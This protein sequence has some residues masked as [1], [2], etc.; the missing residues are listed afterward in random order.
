MDTEAAAPNIAPAEPRPSDN[1]VQSFA[2][3]LSVI[4]SF[5][6]SAPSQTVS[7]VARSTG[8]T[9]AGARRILL[10]LVQLGYMEATGRQFRLTP[11]ILDLGFAYISSLPLWSL[12]EPVLHTLAAQTQE[13]CSAAVLD[14]VDIVHVLRGPTHR[15]MSLHLGV[16]S[17]LPATCT[18]A[19]RVLLA[20]L[21]PDECRQRLQAAPR[22][23][24]TVRTLTEPRALQEAVDAVR[25]QGWCLV[26]Q[27]LEDGLLSLAAPIIDRGGRTVAA[28]DLSG[29]AHRTP[30]ALM[31][32]RFLPLL[33]DAA[34]QVSQLLQAKA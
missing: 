3:G 18:S 34:Q 21:P 2:R 5:S 8:L 26:D 11:R 25:S 23:A 6:H 27:E 30:P 20:T 24:F 10:T 12:A 16:G 13:S 29:Q 28:L 19:G 9:R 32:Q 33:R 31:Q 4:R 22:R 17:R 15:A 14:G 1:Y 7:D